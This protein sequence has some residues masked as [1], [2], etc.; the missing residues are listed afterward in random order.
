VALDVDVAVAGFRTLSDRCLGWLARA[1]EEPL[2]AASRFNDDEDDDDADAAERLLPYVWMVDATLAL[3]PGIGGALRNA[4]RREFS[5]PLPSSSELLSSGDKRSCLWPYVRALVVFSTR[6]GR[7]TDWYER[8][9]WTE[10]TELP[11]FGRFCAPSRLSRHERG[12]LVPVRFFDFLRFED[13]SLAVEVA[14]GTGGCRTSSS[15]S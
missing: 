11:L 15:E 3:P 12:L 9:D 4:V 5:S 10:R 7:N 8:L 2:E 14:L 6:L 13:A 1:E